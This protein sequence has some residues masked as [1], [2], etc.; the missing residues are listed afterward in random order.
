MR[1]LNSDSYKNEKWLYDRQDVIL[2][3][4]YSVKICNKIKFFF[5]LYNF[6]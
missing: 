4:F 6:I 2:S 1:A 3:E 5:S